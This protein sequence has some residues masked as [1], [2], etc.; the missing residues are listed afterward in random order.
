[1][2]AICE[3]GGFQAKFL[4]EQAGDVGAHLC[5]GGSDAGDEFS[6]FVVH[7]H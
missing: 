7:F 1:V 3:A 6:V 5:G 4:F 2:F